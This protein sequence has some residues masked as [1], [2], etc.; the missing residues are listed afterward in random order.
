[1][2]TESQS[3]SHDTLGDLREKY[4]GN[5]Y[6]QNFVLS[7]HYPVPYDGKIPLDND[8][9]NSLD[10]AIVV[11]RHLFAQVSA[12]GRDGWD[13]NPLERMIWAV[14]GEPSGREEQSRARFEILKTCKERVE[15]LQA[16]TFFNLMENRLMWDTVWKRL[17]FMFWHPQI[18]EMVDGADSFELVEFCGEPS[19]LAM[20]GLIEYEGQGTLSDFLSNQLG[21]KR[22]EET[23]TSYLWHFN[24]PVILRVAYVHN[25][26]NGEPK[27]FKDLARISINPHRFKKSEEDGS[28]IYSYDSEDPERV[29]YVL[30]A[31]VCCQNRQ[32]ST[33]RIRL[34][35]ITGQPIAF[36]A[37]SIGRFGGDQW[38]L[39][40]KET[41][42]MLYYALTPAGVPSDVVQ[43]EIAPRRLEP[44][45]L[46]SMEAWM[47]PKEDN[48]G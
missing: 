35:R 41:R 8:D 26:A 13:G 46:R 23:K 14:L 15:G 20:E 1:M 47:T 27:T 9:V 37:D 3:P 43:E 12:D 44:T 11:L 48:R 40:Q 36:A 31:A 4:A 18:V 45:V 34:Y 24:D 16:A 10:A 7:L 39:G 19:Q 25:P 28:F 2:S 38:K 42:Y 5:E 22:D 29:A 32:D 33:D 17:V 6:A 30:V 21:V